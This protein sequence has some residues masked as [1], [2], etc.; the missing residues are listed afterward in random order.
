MICIY[1]YHK[2]VIDPCHFSDKK[3]EASNKKKG[4]YEHVCCNRR[5]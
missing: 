5:S 3:P 4:V 1:K 2:Y